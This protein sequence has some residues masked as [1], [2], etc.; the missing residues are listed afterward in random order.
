MKSKVLVMISD[1]L[2]ITKA[3]ISKSK[4]QKLKN[5]NGK[6]KHQKLKS[7]VLAFSNTKF[8]TKHLKRCFVYFQM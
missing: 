8:K 4:F 6:R 1:F 5:Q 2:K 7:K 3:K